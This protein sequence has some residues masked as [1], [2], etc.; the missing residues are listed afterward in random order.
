[1]VE[2]R[3]NELNNIINSCVVA[4]APQAA[5]AANHRTG[6]LT[7]PLAKAM[8]KITKGVDMPNMMM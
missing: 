7:Q 3:C 4:A 1:M 5:I 2:L 6:T 8:A